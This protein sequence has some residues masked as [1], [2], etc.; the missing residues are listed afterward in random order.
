MER[1]ID[2][3]HPELGTSWQRIEPEKQPF[4]VIQPTFLTLRDG[5]LTSLMRSKHEQIA[6][7]VSTDEGRTWSELKLIDMPNNNSGI[8]SLTLSDGRHLLL[9]NH[10]GGRKSSKEGWGKRNILNLAISNDGQQW[11]AA[12][13]VEKEDEGEFSYPAM[14]QTSDGKVHMTYTWKR[15]RVKHVTVDPSQLKPG[16]VLG[17]EDWDVK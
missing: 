12:G 4:Q 14:I 5:S 2:V 15:Q 16:R 13:T 8:E 10:T 6:K 17:L 7:S 3:Q 9:Y 11:R 1:L